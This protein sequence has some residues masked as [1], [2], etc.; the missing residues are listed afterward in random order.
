MRPPVPEFGLR[1]DAIWKAP[2]PGSFHAFFRA[3]H[4]RSASS[5]HA[6]ELRSSSEHR[7]S[8]IVVQLTGWEENGMPKADRYIP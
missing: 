1:V 4:S 7:R 8:A 2:V 5:H 3:I 6:L